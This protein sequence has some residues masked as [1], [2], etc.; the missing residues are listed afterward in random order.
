MNNFTDIILKNRLGEMNK[1]ERE[2]FKRN[3]FLNEKLRKEYSFQEELDNVM[4]NSLLLE[5]IE[6]DPD[7]IKADILAKNDINNFLKN[8][9]STQ[10]N[11]IAPH[12][13]GIEDE[14]ELRKKIARAEI[15]MFVSGIDVITDAWVKNYNYD[16]KILNM[17]PENQEIYNYIKQSLDTSVTPVRHIRGIFSP[18]SLRVGVSA[19]AVLLFSVILIKSLSFSIADNSQYTKFYEPLDGNSYHMRGSNSINDNDKKLQEGID[20]YLTG[21][22]N[23]AENVLNQIP[24]NTVENPEVLL[25]KGLTKMELNKNAEAIDLFSSLINL[26]DQFVPEAQWYLGLT[27]LKTGETDRAKQLFNVLSKTEGIYKKKSYDI[28]SN[29]NR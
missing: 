28:L 6:S 18:I 4:K 16:K 5:S 24:V 17:F 7:L 3:L 25:Y 9:K 21:K 13:I 15:E 27:L 29:L 2:E 14:V 1:A 19:A 10:K 11:I 20:Y 26:N 22:Y 12:A 23:T 8:K